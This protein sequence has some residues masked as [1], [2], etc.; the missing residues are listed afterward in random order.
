MIRIYHDAR[1]TECQTDKRH[2]NPVGGTCTVPCATYSTA[3]CMRAG[4]GL[5]PG[6][7]ILKRVSEWNCRSCN[8]TSI[9]NSLNTLEE[10]FLYGNLKL[11]AVSLTNEVV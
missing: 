7:M 9:A 1:S 6:N 3:K 10:T 4:P 11:Q 2:R 8:I 5:T